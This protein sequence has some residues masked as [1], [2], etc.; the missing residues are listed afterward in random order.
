M[1]KDIYLIGNAHLDPVWLWRW[2]EGYS[3]V[4]STFKAAL[5]RLKEYPDFIFTCSS[6]IYYK[7]IE[8]D[9]PDMFEQIKKMVQ[10]NRWK[11]VGGWLIQA[12]CNIPSGESFARLGLYGQRYF[13]EKFGEISHT[14]YS[15]DA[16]GQ[17]ANIP[18]LLKKSGMDNYIFQRP[19]HEEQELEAPVFTWVGVD[20][21]A[22]ET[23]RLS[24]G[25]ATNSL[26]ELKE[27][28]KATENSKY[29]NETMLFY[30]VGNHGGGP[31][32][33]MLD[34]IEQL[35]TKGEKLE[36]SDPDSWFKILKKNNAILPTYNDELQHHASGCYSAHSAIKKKYRKAEQELISA[37]KFST[38]SNCLLDRKFDMEKNNELWQQLLFNSF[39]DIIC[40][41]SIK[42]ACDDAI[43]ELGGV[44]QGSKKIANS[45]V[46]AISWRIDTLGNNN[47]VTAL[48]DIGQPVVVFNPHSWDASIPVRIRNFD[49][50]VVAFKVTDSKGNIYPLQLI[51]SEHRM[52]NRDTG[53]DDVDVLFVA[54]VPVFGYGLYYVKVV[55]VAEDVID[56][57]L[58][59]ALMP[60]Y[61]IGDTL[62]VKYGD[63]CIEN[64]FIS[65]VIDKITGT[66]TEV[67]D[68]NTGKIIISNASA[69]AIVL[70]DWENDTWAHQ[71]DYFDD[72]I[73]KFIC[74]RTEV[75]ENGPVRIVVKV[76]SE[77][78]SSTLIQ[79]FMLYNYDK[80]IRVESC[81]DW[82]EKHAICKIRFL[83]NA[84]NCENIRQIPYAS[85]T[86]PCTGEE[87]VTV[88]WFDVTGS[89]DNEEVGLTVSS[90]SKYSFS[91]KDNELSMM[92]CRSSIYADHA[93]VR[94]QIND[95]EY[96]DSGK[97]TF[98]YT[99]TPHT[100]KLKKSEAWRI[101]EEC[102]ADY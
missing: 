28:I 97:S 93:G 84:E 73:G 43:D 60:D 48:K 6:S 35:R 46:G 44:I 14:G 18:Q 62:R 52:T 69:E 47:A 80:T 13:K 1:K 9:E 76:T 23:V 7:W 82:N 88:G 54:K 3:E 78:G 58:K 20:G 50:P 63:I 92:V 5:E 53:Y 27:I 71:M 40:G 37:E 11:V 89:S 55:D 87:Q 21:S 45:A 26:P 90:D 91:A 15:V 29:E 22:V 74:S 42:Q 67:K 51:E 79:K 25:Y 57:E 39:H 64:N 2:Q 75:I 16:F 10:L 99:I 95:Y 41:C 85:I 102:V 83:V 94:K 36:Y 81:I 30:G 96:L 24:N 101:A 56:T 49:K 65:V 66:I 38:L 32:I 34:Y 17:N 4:K 77:Y 68:K 72:V 61:G 33:E 86:K 8:L 100:G 59:L 70:N 12:D 19:S 98:K 31:T